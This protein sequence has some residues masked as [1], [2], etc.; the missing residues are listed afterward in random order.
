MRTTVRICALLVTIVTALS[1]APILG[2]EFVYDARAQIL[3]DGYIHDPSHLLDV[4]TLR[5]L[6]ADT[7]DANRPVHLVALITDAAIWGKSP[8]GYHLSDILL[9]AINS[10]LFLILITGILERAKPGTASLFPAIVGATLFALH[11]IN[12]EA[13]CGGSYREDLLVNFFVLIALLS[14]GWFVAARARH[15]RAACIVCVMALLLAAGSKQ[16]GYMGPALVAVYWLLL[17]RR[18]PSRAWITVVSCSAV[19]IAAFA[20][21]SIHLASENSNVVTTAAQRLG[22]TFTT[23]VTLQLRLWTLM[24]QHVVLPVG[25]SG[26]YTVDSIQHIPT[27]LAVG[28]LVAATGSAIWASTRSR[29]VAFGVAVIALGLAPTSN[30]IPIFHPMADRFLYLPM[31]GLCLIAA[32]AAGQVNR[33]ATPRVL[34][35]CLLS[36]LLIVGIVLG[37]LTVQRELVWRSRVALWTDTLKKSPNSFTAMN[38]LGFAYYDRGDTIRAAETWF[39]VTRLRP[40]RFHADAWAGLAIAMEKLGQRDKADRAFQEAFARDKRYSS[41]PRLIEALIWTPGQAAALQPIADRNI[42]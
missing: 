42:D 26:D 38:N 31:I 35:A 34:R 32:V 10:G 22:G 40:Q 4:I 14:T 12:S 37:A 7:L 18:E 28:V 39:A 2:G 6:S 33:M 27:G 36:G 23:T 16:S 41:P 29:I 19:L 1:Y 5:C 24:L 25:L 9:H 13:V 20:A 11:P 15:R 30:L 21:M 17:R 3:S 8:T